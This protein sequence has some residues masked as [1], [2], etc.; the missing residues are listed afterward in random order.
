VNSYDG[1]AA[2]LASASQS[3]ADADVSEA[4]EL[5]LAL[6]ADVSPEA[7]GCSISEPDGR[8]YR[9]PVSSNELAIVLDYAQ[10]DADDGPCVDAVRVK[11][12]QSW[13]AAEPRYHHFADEAVRHGVRSAISL[14]VGVASRPAALNFYGSGPASFVGEHPNAVAGLLAR[15]VHELLADHSGGAARPIDPGELNAARS[16]HDQVVEAQQRLVSRNGMSLEEAFN[17]LT[18]RSRAE[19][20]SI[21]DVARDVVAGSGADVRGSS[22]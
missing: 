1:W 21:A 3:R 6:S 19:R 11:S 22:T 8:G 4:L 5:A 17:V 13:V 16:M 7:V 18:K 2:L 10:Y 20:C 14:P 12:A 9:T 15:C